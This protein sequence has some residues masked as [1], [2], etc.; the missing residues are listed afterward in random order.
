MPVTPVSEESALIP[1]DYKKTANGRR[2]KG[3]P[4]LCIRRSFDTHGLERRGFEIR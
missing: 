2:S 4:S 1:S 3:N